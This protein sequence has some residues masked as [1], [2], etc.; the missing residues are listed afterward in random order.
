MADA[1]HGF[2]ESGDRPVGNADADAE[3]D[4]ADGAATAD[5]KSKGDGQHHADGSDERV[6]DFFVPLD[7]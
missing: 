1:A 2:G 5:K 3:S 7:G 4:A 6:G